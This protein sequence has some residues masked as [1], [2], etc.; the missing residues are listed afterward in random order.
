MLCMPQV[1]ITRRKLGMAGKKTAEVVLFRFVGVLCTVVRNLYRAIL[2]YMGW[3]C[4]LWLGLGGASSA[5]AHGAANFHSHIEH[6]HI[7]QYSSV[8][9]PERGHAT[10]KV[11]RHTQTVS[12]AWMVSAW[13]VLGFDGLP[14][15]PAE[16]NLWAQRLNILFNPDALWIF[17]EQADCQPMEAIVTSPLL[18]NERLTHQVPSKMH[19]GP[20]HSV[21][22][23]QGLGN[24]V[25][26]K[27]IAGE[28]TSPS[29]FRGHYT[30]RCV[31]MSDLDQLSVTAFAQFP[32]LQKADLSLEAGGWARQTSKR[33]SLTPQVFQI[34]FD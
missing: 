34:A 2:R 7:E 8:S 23:N 16:H 17:N 22:G 26:G 33:L 28:A 24:P 19:A 1:E 15:T 3:S 4:C 10:I 32:S 27:H 9:L 20:A 25:A 21:S 29:F 6:N 18:M 11:L 12:V 31:K 30:F 5:M 13:S 14:R